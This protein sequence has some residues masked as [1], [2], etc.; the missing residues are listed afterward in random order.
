MVET[1]TKYLAPRVYSL[2]QRGV[3][4]NEAPLQDAAAAAAR[5][6]APPSCRQ[7]LVIPELEV[8]G[9]R[10]D[11]WIGCLDEES[12][13][14]RARAGIEPCTA[15]LP[16]SIANVL[17]RL[18]GTA[19]IDRLASPSRRLG[20]R[21]RVLRGISELVERGLAVREEGGIRLSGAWTAAQAEGVA[22]EV[23]MDQWRKA[24]RQVQMWRRFVNGAW[25]VFPDSYLR[26]V[27]RQR[28]GTRGIGLATVNE[29]GELRVIRR[30]RLV[31]G[32]SSARTVLE[33]HLYARWLAEGLDKRARAIERGSIKRRHRGRV[34]AV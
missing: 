7:L 29:G 25:M 6:L 17:R 3:P 34:T 18:G 30:P 5:L 14:Q 15:P 12:F 19:T 10:P 21:S 28:P 8:G 11:L 26:A 32:Q 4:S 2:N 16:L 22:V 27:P 24:L 33:E 20:D 31:I 1:E 9:V 23:K 13:A